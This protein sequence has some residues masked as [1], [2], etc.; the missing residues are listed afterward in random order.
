MFLVGNENRNKFDLQTNTSRKSNI[1]KKFKSVFRV[2]FS[3]WKLSEVNYAQVR[4]IRVISNFGVNYFSNYNAGFS[5]ADFPDG[6]MLI[7]F[8]QDKI[9]AERIKGSKIFWINHRNNRI[10]SSK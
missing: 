1:K 5:Q 9:G 3:R 6:A 4:L 10:G 7:A 2:L 8:G